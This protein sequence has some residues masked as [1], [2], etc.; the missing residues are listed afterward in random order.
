MER[1]TTSKDIT[2]F[3]RLIQKQYKGP[4]DGEK[5]YNNILGTERQNNLNQLQIT[6]KKRE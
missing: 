1:Q 3:K 4:K 5:E 2:I 6:M